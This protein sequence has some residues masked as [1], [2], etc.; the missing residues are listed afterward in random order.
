V[1]QRKLKQRN[2]PTQEELR[3]HRRKHD[4]LLHAKLEESR[5]NQ[6]EATASNARAIKRQQ[7]VASA[8]ETALEQ[9]GEG[10]ELVVDGTSPLR[11]RRGKKGA[12]HAEPGESEEK[13]AK[14][15]RK[16]KQKAG[17]QER[18]EGAEDHGFSPAKPHRQREPSFEGE[19]SSGKQ[20]TVDDALAVEESLFG[21]SAGQSDKGEPLGTDTDQRSSAAPPL[22]V[23]LK[24]DASAAA[25]AVEKIPAL[26][27]QAIP[28]YCASD[29]LEVLATAD[30][31]AQPG[32]RGEGSSQ[33]PQVLPGVKVTS[34][35]A[36]VFLRP[37]PP[38]S[39]AQKLMG[40]V[41]APV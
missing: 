3:E 22:H 15:Q 37:A 12:A 2:N 24:F 35:S 6:A 14:A 39:D 10:A 8:V 38:H 41:Q 17:G 9:G 20:D 21:S 1:Q 29:W 27:A 7:A 5:R 30:V 19:S 16:S 13:P 11:R 23:P 28:D 31:D 4:E 34:S 26:S 36:Q 25:A 40:A 32:S 18:A 33:Q